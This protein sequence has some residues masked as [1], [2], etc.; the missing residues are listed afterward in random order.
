MPM[1]N[2]LTPSRTLARTIAE[3]RPAFLGFTTQLFERKSELAPAF[4]K[5][6]SMWERETGRGLA[7]F[8]RELDP[9][10]PAERDAYANHRSFQAAWY[11]VRTAR[12]PAE[13]AG[14]RTVTPFQMLASFIKSVQPLLDDSRIWHEVARASRWNTRDLERLKMAVAKAK[15][16]PLLKHQPRLVRFERGGAATTPAAMAADRS[17]K[18]A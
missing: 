15:P 8:V 11:L 10:M 6:F 9:D 13:K 18:P 17:K 5:A 16:M 14:R 7:A 2:T 1:H 3:L 12:K 4:L